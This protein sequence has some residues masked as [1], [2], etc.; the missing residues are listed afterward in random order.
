MNAASRDAS[1][2]DLP[3]C[4]YCWARR[5]EPCRTGSD[6]VSWPHSIRISDHQDSM[7]VV[8]RDTAAAAREHDER[9]RADER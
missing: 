7:R 5:G 4:R 8:L 6:R 2:R 1:D 3:P 9:V